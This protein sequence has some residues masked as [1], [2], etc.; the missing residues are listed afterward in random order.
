MSPANTPLI[1]EP[2]DSANLIY[3]Y[4]EKK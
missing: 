1:A 3:G 4:P 2:R